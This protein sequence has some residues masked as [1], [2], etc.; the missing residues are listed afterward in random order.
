LLPRCRFMVKFL[1]LLI[2]AFGFLSKPAYALYGFKLDGTLDKEAISH[3]YF[4]GNFSRVLPPLEAFKSSFGTN[5][6]VSKEDSVFVYKYLSVI[7]AS[8]P[9]TR[10]KGEAYM[11]E[12]IKIVPAVQLIDLYVSDNIEAIFNNVKK[13]YLHKSD[14][15]PT[16]GKKGD[17]KN[18]LGKSNSNEWMWWTGAGVGIVA[19]TGIVFLIVENSKT[20]E[21]PYKVR[22]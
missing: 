22:P 14:H 15:Q 9:K 1:T 20:S 3:D 4:E 6:A 11:L 16:P 18:H 13:S 5:T 17:T 2:A 21:A 19:T 12:L 10:Q 8:D 7:Y